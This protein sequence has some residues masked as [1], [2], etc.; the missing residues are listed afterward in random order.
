MKRINPTYKPDVIEVY[1]EEGID[2]QEFRK[3]LTEK[4]GRSL[5]DAASSKAENGTYEERIRAEAEQQIAELMASNGATHIEYSIQFGDTII[6]GN[7][8]NFVVSAI[9]NM[10]EIMITQ[11][12]SSCMAIRIVTAVFMA[13]SAVVVMIILFILMESAI[14]RDRREFGIM[15]GLGYTSRE[16]M[17]QLACR[18]V[19]SAVFSVFIGTVI[20]VTMTDLLTSIIGVVKVNIPQVIVLD[21]VMLIFCFVC[22]YVGARKIKTIS[23]YELMTE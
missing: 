12:G 15:K 19:P 6:S 18:I 17:F 2:A 10:G 20:G 13:I 21:I 7:S 14:R 22:A 8:S 4:Y 23:V 1:L 11:L 9:T 3:I 5:S 16:L